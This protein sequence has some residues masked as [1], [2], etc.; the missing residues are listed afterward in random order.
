MV[1]WAAMID[2]QIDFAGGREVLWTWERML[3]KTRLIWKR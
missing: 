3:L 1:G 2:W